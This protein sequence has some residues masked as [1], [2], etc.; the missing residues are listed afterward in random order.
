MLL[1]SLVWDAC[2][3]NHHYVDIV[4]RGGFICG[5]LDVAGADRWSW[6]KDLEERKKALMS[7]YYY[8]D[9]WAHYPSAVARPSQK[10]ETFD[11][12]KFE[13]LADEIMSQLLTPRQREMAEWHCCSP[14]VLDEMGLRRIMSE[15]E[16][17]LDASVMCSILANA[18]KIEEAF[19]L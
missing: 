15:E 2:K 4:K 18:Y 16:W 8:F 14:R 9:K 11:F 17:Q 7:I 6:T 5:G 19:H 12:S 3:D 10:Y 13:T 1:K